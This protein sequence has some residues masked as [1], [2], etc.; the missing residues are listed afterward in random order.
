M[1]SDYNEHTRETTILS[2]EICTS[3]V[4]NKIGYI[5]PGKY[6]IK[7]NTALSR[8]GRVYANT[9]YVECNQKQIKL[10]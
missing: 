10:R 6:N 8:M 3:K 2:S 9:A 7:Q 5:P 4:Y 1:Q